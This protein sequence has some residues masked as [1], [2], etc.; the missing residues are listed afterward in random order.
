MILN[1]IIAA[2]ISLALSPK[3]EFIINAYEEFIPNKLTIL[4]INGNEQPHPLIIPLKALANAPNPVPTKDIFVLTVCNIEEMLTEESTEVVATIIYIR[5][6]G[7]FKI[8]I[9]P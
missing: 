7:T 8:K 4:R 3:N 5:Y 2:I 9:I 6:T 1:A